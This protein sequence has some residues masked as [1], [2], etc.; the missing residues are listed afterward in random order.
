MEAIREPL[1]L[2]LAEDVGATVLLTEKALE[3]SGVG[4]TLSI[5]NDGEEALQYLYREGRYREADDY[6]E[7]NVIL[8]DLNL[9]KVDGRVV[10]RK[11]K[12]DEK[13]NRIPVVVMTNSDD[14]E[15]IRACYEAGASIYVTKPTRFEGYVEL[16]KSVERYWKLAE[17]VRDPEMAQIAKAENVSTVSASSEAE[18]ASK[19]IDLLVVDDD[20]PTVLLI[21]TLLERSDQAFVVRS[22]GDRDEAFEQIEKRCPGCLILDHYLP[23]TNSLEIMKELG[24]RGYDIPVVLLTGSYDPRFSESAL[25]CGATHVLHK[26]ELSQ[27]ELGEIVIESIQKKG[28]TGIPPLEPPTASQSADL[29]GDLVET[30]DEAVVSTDKRGT[31]VYTSNKVRDTLG[32]EPITLLGKDAFA[33]DGPFEGKLTHPKGGSEPQLSEIELSRGDGDGRRLQVRL[34]AVRPGEDGYEKSVVVIF[35]ELIGS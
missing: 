10:L 4:T 1:H 16:V 6:R 33:S 8:L 14:P 12:A 9:P 3:K 21:E 28:M 25:Q 26:G 15:D 23:G 29:F 7:P 24:S 34:M 32:V 11:I 20:P 13:L 18:P 31:V 2:L 17:V 19:S 30:I 35:K 22:A 5:V 27:F